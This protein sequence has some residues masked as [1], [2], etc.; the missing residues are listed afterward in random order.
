MAYRVMKT[1]LEGLKI[2]FDSS[3]DKYFYLAVI[4]GIVHV[5]LFLYNGQSLI[6]CVRGRS[7]R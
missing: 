1:N 5:L 4:W 7:G 2:V 3:S 6:F